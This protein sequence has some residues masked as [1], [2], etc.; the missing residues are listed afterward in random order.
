M[1]A[2]AALT[3]IR[4][5]LAALAAPDALQLS[6]RDPADP[7]DAAS[8]AERTSLSAARLH[9]LSAVPVTTARRRIRRALD[10]LRAAA[11]ARDAWDAD[12][13]DRLVRVKRDTA[14]RQKLLTRAKGALD[15]CKRLAV[16]EDPFASPGIVVIQKL[17]A[18]AE[19][20]GATTVE[21]T[22]DTSA[23][24]VTDDPSAPVSG[25]PLLTVC[26]SKFLADFQFGPVSSVTTHV[27]VRFRHLAA[28]SREIGDSDVDAHFASLVRGLDFVALRVAFQRLV[29]QEKLDELLRP[30]IA[31]KDALRF[32]EDDLFAIQA[33]E[34]AAGDSDD[35]RMA[36]G[37]GLMQRSAHGLRIQFM[38]GRFAVLGVED[39]VPPRDILAASSMP[40]V[41]QA[42][43]RQ[44][45]APLSFMYPGTKL[46]CVGAQYVLTF[47]EPI[48][49]TL[50]VALDLERIVTFVDTGNDDATRGS[51]SIQDAKV[52]APITGAGG[53]DGGSAASNIDGSLGGARMGSKSFPSIQALLAPRVFA[54]RRSSRH[55]P[56]ANVTGPLSGLAGVGVGSVK[57][58]AV[59]S[60]PEG[61]VKSAAAPSTAAGDVQVNDSGGSE[62]KNPPESYYSEHTDEYIAPAALQNNQYMT[63]SHSGTDLIPGLEVRRVPLCHPREVHSV[64]AIIRQQLVFNE[65]LV[66]CFGD[67]DSV[68][69]SSSPLITQLVEVVTCDSPGF[70]HFCMYDAISDDVI[71]LA[72]SISLGGAVSAKLK[73]FN[74]GL[75]SCSDAKATALLRASRSVPLTVLAI[76]KIAACAA[77]SAAV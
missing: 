64:F 40:T 55:N 71:G 51:L 11:A 77:S 73:P 33:A 28:D 14:S 59:G 18:A 41:L 15:E 45:G 35:D 56:S 3:E 47:E 54:N 19:A 24:P 1:T 21:E 22:P 66:S 9:S 13:S 25:G 4:S 26:G 75:H 23:V 49:T 16:T 38:P 42:D 36:Q 6:S 48:V 27:D 65:L 32:F 61:S 44:S 52:R 5:A 76:H 12:I 58:P 67:P 31:L 60:L 53:R 37:H 7:N 34:S 70:M 30:Q 68:S 46:V 20:A 39:A 72:V 8:E 29:N 69:S 2:A 57:V 62:S 10:T 63:F 50:S 74:G 17:K 43:S